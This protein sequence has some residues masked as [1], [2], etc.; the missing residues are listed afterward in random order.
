MHNNFTK[1]LIFC[2][3]FLYWNLKIIFYKVDVENQIKCKF[4]EFCPTFFSCEVG[5]NSANLCFIW[6]STSTLR[7][8]VFSSA[9]WLLDWN[10]ILQN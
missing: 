2:E 10:E 8:M 6:F 9:Y 4:A 1:I 3:L 5:Q 7:K